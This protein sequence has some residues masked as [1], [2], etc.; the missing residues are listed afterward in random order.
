MKIVIAMAGEGSRFRKIGIGIPKHEIIVREKSLFEWSMLSLSDF[1][2]EEFIFITRKGFYNK[3]FIDKKCT[4][5]GIYEYEILE[6]DYL[7]DGQARTVMCA[8][9]LISNEDDILIYNIDT[10]VKEGSILKS[11]ILDDF[12]GFIPIFNA[13]GDKWS[14]VKLDN[15]GN[16]ID[17]AEKKRISNW[18]S[19]GMYYFKSWSMYKEIFNDFEQEIK[20]EFTETYIAPMYKKLIIQGSRIGVRKIDEA[21]VHVLGTPEDVDIF[22]KT[23]AL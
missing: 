15:E 2:D 22:V 4:K 23:F 7:T 14:F 16:V 8:D 21:N 13:H 6:I 1:F 11:D 9:Q 12:F 5:L 19:V 17:V 10:Y 3:E 18:G 20:N